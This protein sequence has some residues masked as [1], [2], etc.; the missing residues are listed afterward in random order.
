MAVNNKIYVKEKKYLELVKKA[1]NKLIKDIQDSVDKDAKDIKELKKFMWDNLTDYTDEERGIALHEVDHSVNLTNERIKSIT[2]YEKAEN[3]PYFAKLIFDSDEFEELFPVYVGI[4]TIEEDSNF[5]V[6]DWRAPISSL[7]YNYELGAAKYSAP[8][9][10]ITGKIIEKMQFKIENGEIIR[11]FQSDI[12][13]DDDFLQEI[14]TKSS[15]SK[16]QNIVSTIQK[17][18]NEIIRNKFDKY[19]IVQGAAGSGKTSV[20]LHR[21]AYL[22]Y[23]NLNLLSNNVLI[24]SPNNI[25]SD[26]I[27]SVLPELGEEDVLKSVFSDF[28]LD[29]LKPYK[30]TEKFGEFLHRFY[31]DSNLKDKNI[32]Y[33]MSDEYQNDL[34]TFID[35]YINSVKFINTISYNQQKITNTELDNLYQKFSKFPLKER[36]ELITD[37]ICNEWGLPQKKY[38]SILK[39]NIIKNCDVNLNFNEIYQKFLNHKKLESFKLTDG[40]IKYEDQV[41]L[42]YTNFAINGFPNMNYIKHIIIDE[43]QDYTPFQLEILQRIFNTSSFTVLGDV[44][45]SINP[46]NNYDSLK[47]L[48]KIFDKAKYLELTKTYRS[49]EEIINYTNSILGLNNVFSVRHNTEMPVEIKKVSEIELI[50]N[51]ITDLKNMDDLGLEKI[52][53]ITRDIDEAKNLYLKLEDYELDIQLLVSSEDVVKDSKILIPSYLSKGLEFDGVIGPSEPRESSRQCCLPFGYCS[54]SCSSTSVSW[55]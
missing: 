17:E 8:D 9:G 30:K 43:V 22:L 46:Y 27:S 16:M 26:Y 48:M 12:N 21:I 18:Q 14:L 31:K 47:S 44:N 20:G 36:F 1:L 50:N 45:Q 52:A 35:S 55:P 4:T 6:F 51:L 3:S 38:F 49:S 42:L 25:F 33:K 23:Q 11:C 54:H 13:I 53:I 40:K 32:S 15:S 37:S 2:K 34:K 29:Y 28:V 10:D 5:Y 41:G 39:R 19:L 24:F 7:F